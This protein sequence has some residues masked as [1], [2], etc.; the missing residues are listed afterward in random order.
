VYRHHRQH[1]KNNIPARQYL[2]VI[3][4]DSEANRKKKI[5]AKP[6]NEFINDDP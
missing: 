1:I 5:C 4:E 3:Y 2:K 6:V